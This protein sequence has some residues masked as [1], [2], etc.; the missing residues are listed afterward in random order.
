MNQQEYVAELKR[1]L[2]FRGASRRRANDI[3]AEV[4]SHL[5]DSG[6][7][8]LETFGTPDRYAESVL[9]G[10]RWPTAR[11]MAMMVLAVTGGGLTSAAFSDLMDGEPVATVRT[12]DLALW[13]VFALVCPVGLLPAVTRRLP[14]VGTRIAILVPVAGVI[15]GAAGYIADH[16]PEE[17]TLFGCRPGLALA[18]GLGLLVAAGLVE[19]L[20]RLLRRA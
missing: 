11:L 15:A 12:A 10:P 17:R 19:V 8:P 16:L 6:E 5:A 9:R 14:S 3:L 4:Q 2:S 13:L 20:S 18:V 7:D 1:R